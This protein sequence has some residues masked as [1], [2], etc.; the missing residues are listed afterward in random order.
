MK[1]TDIMP[2]GEH[3]CKE[4]QNVPDSYL[5]WLYDNGKANGKV[6]HYIIENL[7][8]IKYNLGKK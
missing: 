3:K 4:M 1:D 6:L 2:W 7:D 8:S 5:F